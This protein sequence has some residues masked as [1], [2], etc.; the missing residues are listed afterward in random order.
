ML[1]I[2]R[3]DSVRVFEE[4]MARV[5]RNQVEQ[6]RKNSAKEL[7]IQQVLQD[8]YNAEQAKIESKRQESNAILKLNKHL[9]EFRTENEKIKKEIE[10][11]ADK[12]NFENHFNLRF[13]TSLI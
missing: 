7:E 13:G 12:A 10:Y 3:Q 8:R 2:H 11:A 6:E 4:H 9:A 1:Y 5:K